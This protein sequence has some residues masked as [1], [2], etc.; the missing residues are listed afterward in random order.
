MENLIVVQ[1][2]PEQAKEAAL[3]NKHYTFIKLLESV[4]V[5]EL[6]SGT[7]TISFDKFGRVGNIDVNKHYNIDLTPSVDKL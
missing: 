6:K 2:T 5:F 1:F 7:V 3:L 4:G